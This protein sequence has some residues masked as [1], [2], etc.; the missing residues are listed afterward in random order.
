[1]RTGPD[2]RVCHKV[3][4]RKYAAQARAARLKARARRVATRARPSM[5]DRL[6]AAGH[7]EGEGSIMLLSGGRKCVSLPRISLASTDR[8]VIDFF[9]AT[10]PGHVT[11][12]QPRSKNGV[13]KAAFKW[14]LE[15][16]ET[17]EGFVLDIRP[18]LKR[19]TVAARADLMV[20]DLRARA[21]LR[22]T[23][24]ARAAKLERMA[25]MRAL[26]RRGIAVV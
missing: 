21:D 17:I 5:A 19:R 15:R 22:Q 6:W 20:E 24:A 23:P 4:Q 11:R 16:S 7:F 1:M 10:W 26:N 8:A 18:F 25:R 14:T 13:A 12:H 2:C 9:Q 3:L